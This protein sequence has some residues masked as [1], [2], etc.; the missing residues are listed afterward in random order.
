MLVL[1]IRNLITSR[2]VGDLSGNRGHCVGAVFIFSAHAKVG[3]L[4]DVTLSHKAVPSSKITMD[5]ML[6]LQISHA[7]Y[8]G[9]N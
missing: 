7:L 3:Y 8:R 9:I 4:D 6:S 5:A 1:S 2:A